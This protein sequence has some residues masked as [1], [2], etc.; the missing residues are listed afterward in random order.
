LNFAQLKAER[1]LRADAFW[2]P[3]AVP[4]DGV[5]KLLAA[6]PIASLLQMNFACG[7]PRTPGNTLSTGMEGLVRIER[8]RKC[9]NAER[10]L[11]VAARKARLGESTMTLYERIQVVAM[12]AMPTSSP[13]VCRLCGASARSVMMALREL[14]DNGKIV[15]AN[16][17][18]G[19]SGY[20]VFDL[21]PGVVRPD[22]ARV[23]L[24]KDELVKFRGVRSKKHLA[25]GG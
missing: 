21:A 19:R 1:M 12:G 7:H 5:A 22:D 15:V 23:S 16:G 25:A 17:R 18:R 24:A 6:M 2:L 9:Y 8:C 10:D 14:Q 11:I 4:L 20:I 13:A 3:F